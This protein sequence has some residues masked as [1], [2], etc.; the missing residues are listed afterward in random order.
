MRHCVSEARAVY[1]DYNHGQFSEKLAEWAISMME[2]KDAAGRKVKL[3]PTPAESVMAAMTKIGA[4]VPESQEY[5]AWYL[6]NMAR[7]DYPKAL[8]TDVARAH[9]VDETINDPDCE[10]TAVLA[11]FR[12]KMDVMDV[13][14]H[15]E[16]FL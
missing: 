10:P 5:T 1:E 9:F 8:T 7:A 15:W 11:C 14:I 6:F 3:T 12:A 4:K 13:P 16:R 2:V